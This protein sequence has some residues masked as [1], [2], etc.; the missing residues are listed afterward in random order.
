MLAYIIP[1]NEDDL[2]S[3]AALIK[4]QIVLFF[5][6]SIKKPVRN[7]WLDQQNNFR[8]YDFPDN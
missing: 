1:R 6:W 2:L 5:Q 4:M 3:R 7:C 8:M